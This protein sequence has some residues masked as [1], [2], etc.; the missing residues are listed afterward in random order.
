MMTVVLAACT[1]TTI[2]EPYYRP[3]DA[4]I[5]QAYLSPGADFRVYTKVM[6]SPLEIYYP[7]NAPPPA[8]AVLERLR[9]TF[10]TAFLEALGED[11]VVVDEAGPDVMHVIGQ[12]VDLKI[13]GATGTFDATGRLEDLV[14]Q[15]QLTLLMEFRDSQTGRVLARAAETEPGRATAVTD[16]PASWAEVE[17][18]ARRWA[19]LFR[20]FLD[21]HLGRG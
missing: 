12:V 1:T 7:D 9:Q 11:Y 16:E 10:R 19:G 4:R 18:A 14:A 6:A 2:V 5:E 17:L 15:G 13:A 3:A 20:L 21:E 8:E